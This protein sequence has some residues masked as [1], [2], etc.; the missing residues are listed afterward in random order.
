MKRREIPIGSFLSEQKTTEKLCP[1]TTQ[2]WLIANCLTVACQPTHVTAPNRAL[3]SSSHLVPLNSTE[4]SWFWRTFAVSWPATRWG[5]A[6]FGAFLPSSTNTLIGGPN[7]FSRTAHTGL[8]WTNRQPS[9]QQRA[10]ARLRA[11]VG[12]ERA[13]FNCSPKASDFA[14]QPPHSVGCASRNVPARPRAR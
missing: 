2:I 13:F 11:T 5:L 3:S 12:A 1:H 8:R 7:G 10:L 6:R 4:M 9:H 14:H